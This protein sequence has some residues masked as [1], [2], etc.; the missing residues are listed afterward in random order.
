MRCIT[1]A[2][3]ALIGCLVLLLSLSGFSQTSEDDVKKQAQKF[4]DVGDFTSALPLYSQLLSFYAKDPNY[5]YRYGVCALEAGND[6]EKPISYL[7]FA[8][9]NKEVNNNVFYYL[10]K[11]YHLNYRFASALN[12][13]NTYK[14]KAPKPEQEKLQVDRQLEMCRNG[15]ELLKNISDLTVMDKKELALTDYFRAYDLSSIGLKL[16][17]KPDDFKTDFDKKKN[18]ES[19]VVLNPTKSEIYFSSYG[20]NDK[21]GK[22]IYKVKR[23]DNGDWTNPIRLDNSINT[24]F[25]EDFPFLSND[26]TTLYFCSKGHNSMGGYDV[27][28]SSYNSAAGTWGAPENMDF[29]INT[30]DDDMLYI[31]DEINKV[32][33]FSSR[34][35]SGQGNINVYKIKVGP[36]PPSIALISGVFSSVDE[37][38]HPE[39]TIT[40]RDSKTKAIIGVYKT[41]PKTGNYSIPLPSSGTYIFN[42]ESE[43]S[44]MKTETVVVPEK[45]DLG[46]LQQKIN[47][48]NDKL[49]VQNIFE[50]AA[51]NEANLMAL[52]KAKANL[53]VNYVAEV[54]P[55]VTE[56]PKVSNLSNQELVNIAYQDAKDTKAEADQLRAKSEQAY[57]VSKSKMD[58]S[59]S[60][61]NT[62]DV[63]EKSA[64]SIANNQQK[65]SELEKVNQ[66]KREAKSNT[67]QASA[68]YT[69]AQN[70]EEDANAKQAEADKSLN[71]AKELDNAI[72]INSKE[73]IARL[74]A[75]KSTLQETTPTKNLAEVSVTELND[76]AESKQQDADAAQSR[77]KIV[78]TE[79]LDIDLKVETLSKDKASA[80]G[81]Q[82]AEIE[83]QLDELKVQKAERQNQLAD[84]Y[85]T[86]NQ[87]QQEADDL[88]SQSEFI[89]SAMNE[90][91]SGSSNL[92]APTP[93]EKITLGNE[94]AID[95]GRANA[96]AKVDEKP[97]LQVNNS[98]INDNAS[99]AFL[100]TDIGKT[101]VT[102]DNF[103]QKMAQANKI[104][105]PVKREEQKNKVRSQMNS[106]WEKNITELKTQQA[107][108]KD[109]NERAAMQSRITELENLK[110]M[111]SPTPEVALTTAA[112][113]SQNANKQAETVTKEPI[114]ASSQPTKST[115]TA[116]VDSVSSVSASPIKSDGAELAL[117]SG[118]QKND[119]LA[120]AETANTAS[121]PNQVPVNATATNAEQTTIKQGET[122]SSQ[123]VV[124]KDSTN[125]N[126]QTGIAAAETTPKSGTS[127]NSESTTSV[128]TQ[129][130]ETSAISGQASTT[131]ANQT[132]VVPAA[133]NA[134]PVNV[135]KL[136]SDFDL[137]LSA[138]DQLANATEKEQ[139]KQKLASTWKGIS[140]EEIA[141]TKL[142]LNSA[143]NS[144]DIA[145]LS[146]TLVELE[147]LKA[148]V[149]TSATPVS[150]EV[151]AAVP[152][153]ASNPDLAV[154]SES[155][156]QTTP[157][158][159][160]NATATEIKEGNEPAVN[161]SN[162]AALETAFTTEPAKAQARRADRL[163]GEAAQL[164]LTEDSLTKVLVTTSDSTEKISVEKQLA[165]AQKEIFVKRIDALKAYSVANNVE[166]NENTEQLKRASVNKGTIDADEVSR[167]E[168]LVAEAAYY[169]NEASIKSELNKS[170]TDATVKE[171]ELKKIVDLE[172]TALEKQRR[173]LSTYGVTPSLAVST[174][175]SKSNQQIV[176]APVASAT[177]PTSSEDEG[178]I[179]Q[180]TSSSQPA[181]TEIAA[182]AETSKVNTQN[183]TTA[184]VAENKNQS[185]E[186]GSVVVSAPVAASNQQSPAVSMELIKER[187]R[188]FVY[189]TDT[190]RVNTRLSV[191]EYDSIVK[192]PYY[193]Y[194][195]KLLVTATE[196][197]QQAAYYSSRGETLKA[198]SVSDSLRAEDFILQASQTRDTLKMQE[199]I[200]KAAEATFLSNQNKLA[201]DSS[202]GA[203]R[204][205]NMAAVENKSNAS[206]YVTRLDE[207]DRIKLV[208]VMNYRKP[209]E[210]TVASLAAN[211]SDN[212]KTS[213][214]S[215]P[216]AT[217]QPVTSSQTKV[218]SEPTPE[219][220]LKVEAVEIASKQDTLSTLAN[221]ESPKA[222]VGERALVANNQDLQVAESASVTNA[223]KELSTV[224]N[225]RNEL[226]KEA[227]FTKVNRA[228]Y[229]KNNPIPINTLLP[230]GIIFK[231][232]IG[233]FRNP[234]PQDLFKGFDPISGETSTTGITRYT[235][236]Y[237]KNFEAANSAKREING[238]GYKDAFVV[239]FCN[240]KR[241]SI[242]EATAMI[243]E[244]RTCAG[245]NLA[246]N[247]V[248]LPNTTPTPVA[249]LEQVVEQ[250]EVKPASGGTFAENAIR[251]E[252]SRSEEQ[253]QA[254]VSPSIQKDTAVAQKAELKVSET[255]SSQASP[256]STVESTSGPVA[257][258]VSFEEVKGLVYTIQVGVYS[259]QILANQ[260]FN[261]QPLYFERTATGLYR[262]TSG[263]FDNLETAGQAK[264]SIVAI[265]VKDAFI[266][267]YFNGARITVEE[268]KRLEQEQGKAVFASSANLNKLPETSANAK[269]TG[270]STAVPTVKIERE[271]EQSRVGDGN[272]KIALPVE[273]L[274]NQANNAVVFK[275]QIG[276]FRSEIPL[277]IA[278][279]FLKLSNRGIE[280]YRTS[281]SLNIY[282]I[283]NFRDVKSANSLKDEV[284]QEGLP[285]A[286]VVA[287][288]GGN[289]MKIEDAIK[290]V[291]NK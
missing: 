288:K 263:I 85:A 62:A 5:N 223:G 21:N 254:V 70:L 173:A 200:G 123:N 179:E 237:F 261:I 242:P 260:L 74:T 22:D 53:D 61:L 39:A 24:A 10:G 273:G 83:K 272:N 95:L 158:N 241:I 47:L 72:Q 116:A 184:V 71:Y 199:L 42:V 259:K 220:T 67:L 35:T 221:T 234:I 251:N 256:Q 231:V 130:T 233:A 214:S 175:N 38:T 136:E 127:P 246:E 114:V 285:D 271:A 205:L 28:K 142:Q 109:K 86:A 65:A 44:A 206:R 25:D 100:T 20:N 104:T 189:P 257:P 207:L 149:S 268:A 128:V 168:M 201:S 208:A 159:A 280:S 227:V 289:K 41:D 12:A 248:T 283:G 14:I 157:V 134:E 78:L 90:L 279:I 145:N 105:D 191:V 141:K 140:E 64:Q 166:F 266:T 11:A 94:L 60:K 160:N 281:D 55:V 1:K 244:G 278:A 15:M 97:V 161:Q 84:T 210:E 108:S 224:V 125:A 6:R 4:F 34:R 82:V 282:T 36:K 249:P 252:Q 232:Q 138:L 19:V 212:N 277:E 162:G 146:A 151:V 180:S 265:G 275:V 76:K 121:S 58:V 204:R 203:S 225:E 155:K 139:A 185:Q 154:V 196:N 270:L 240:G 262:Y 54:I 172:K 46:T 23:M 165:S 117:N 258:S 118:S 79:I 217:T 226:V 287:F 178:A 211:T 169:Y 198:A 135:G 243:R 29:A 92:P 119:S 52:L 27:F 164:K 195:N 144:E 96:L 110:A 219:S 239:A 193:N 57:A 222:E 147:E 111:N 236:G 30:P 190:M 101:P 216:L 80:S 66:L 73:S 230:S 8:S 122:Q 63:L 286:F 9:R 182:A 177:R 68:I 77:S 45:K 153:T 16:L 40:V 188:A 215:L 37:N 132:D 269:I 129:Q 103:N 174:D 33:Y 89:A 113:A 48:T 32:A 115:N 238:I 250:P 112:E 69:I 187:E 107:N 171:E 274:K 56:E 255:A 13:Y 247:K 98:D 290:E 59:K 186:V 150:N 50:D 170:V 197:M 291:N 43:V 87:L 102:A 228:V 148:K 209:G 229:N 133:E 194:Y 31:A 235:A 245:S 167:A 152:A 213:T 93:Q 106:N 7:E 124:L 3:F 218:A 264:A 88:K 49:I 163:N 120:K 276:V 51:I 192:S 91:K 284:I 156:P 18:E 81:A 202:L 75:Q 131:Q 183:T 267:S 181:K 176:T 253:Q 137:Q 2:C 143:K 126:Q 99:D 26:G 17:V